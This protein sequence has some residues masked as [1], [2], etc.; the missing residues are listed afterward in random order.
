MLH[1]DM[2]RITLETRRD[3]LLR[4]AER[5][6]LAQELPR[7]RSIVRTTVCHVLRALADAL[8]RPAVDWEVAK[9]SDALR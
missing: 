6:R 5:D 7:P 1:P 8:E 2:L 3:D 4:E 9:A